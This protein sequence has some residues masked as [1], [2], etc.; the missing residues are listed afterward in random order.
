MP[1]CKSCGAD[2]RFITLKSGKMMPVNTSPIMIE[3]KAGDTGIITEDGRVSIGRLQNVQSTN[4]HLMRG[5]ITH[6][7]TCPYASAFRR[8]EAGKR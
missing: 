8:G 3:D 7:K 6:F 5:Y 4:G 2:I 1:K